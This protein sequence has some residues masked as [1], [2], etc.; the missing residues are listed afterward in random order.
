MKKMQISNEDNFKTQ[1]TTIENL[2]QLKF[3]T[4]I[5]ILVDDNFKVI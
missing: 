1:K 3:Q 4:T 5:E 2:R